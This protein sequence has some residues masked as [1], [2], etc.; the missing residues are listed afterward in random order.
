MNTNK[1]LATISALLV[2]LLLFGCGSVTD[3][4]PPAAEE[5]LQTEAQTMART[6]TGV[7]FCLVL[8]SMA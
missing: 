8:L 4:T 5:P 1:R 6:L 7:S 3:T 2:S